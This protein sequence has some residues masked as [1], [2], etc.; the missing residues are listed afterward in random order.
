MMRLASQVHCLWTETDSI[1]V[2]AAEDHGLQSHGDLRAS[3]TRKRGFDSFAACQLDYVFPGAI[4]QQ[5]NPAFARQGSGCNSRSL[6]HVTKHGVVAQRGERFDGIEEVAGAIPVD[7]TNDTRGTRGY[8]KA[9]NRSSKPTRG[10]RFP[11]S[12]LANE[13]SRARGEDAR[14]QNGK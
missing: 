5:E 13:V 8:P 14:L 9:G 2:W 3:K 4:F 12:A 11:L 6:H 1:S 7:S 10:V